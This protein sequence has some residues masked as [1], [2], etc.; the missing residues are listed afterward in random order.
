M[1]L[2]RKPDAS[3]EASEG[4]NSSP[5]DMTGLRAFLFSI[6]MKFSCWRSIFAVHRAL[7]PAMGHF[8]PVFPHM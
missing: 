5:T 3:E 4:T 6:V 8:V 1:P 7:P 2:L